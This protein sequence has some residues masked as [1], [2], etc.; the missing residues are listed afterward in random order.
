MQVVRAD[1]EESRKVCEALRAAEAA[2]CAARDDKARKVEEMQASNRS[3]QS[4]LQVR[5]ECETSVVEQQQGYVAS[6][7]ARLRQPGLQV[8]EHAD[9]VDGGE[10]GRRAETVVGA[11][12]AEVAGLLS[13]LRD[14]LS[15]HEAAHA[16]VTAA[17]EKAEREGAL[18]TR[19]L[20]EQRK[21]TVEAMSKLEAYERELKEKLAALP[22]AD[23]PTEPPAA[24][25]APSTRTSHMVELQPLEKGDTLVPDAP[26]PPV[27]L[28]S[29]R[30]SAEIA[31]QA[32]LLIDRVSYSMRRS[33]DAKT[34]RGG[35]GKGV[36]DS[37]PES[38]V[39]V[40]SSLEVSQRQ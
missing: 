11:S 3:R 35:A 21:A 2:A 28:R 22:S 26:S 15:A 34:S 36:A 1:L 23:A 31:D 20:T 8:P 30:S 29:L 10:L 9:G 14:E 40:V 7:R 12:A 39:A 6:L 38:P 32:S 33:F 4:A 5:I 37:R 17:R 19:R 16:G 27:D 18:E 25:P 13:Q 24:P